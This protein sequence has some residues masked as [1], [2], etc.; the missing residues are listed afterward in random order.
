MMR[1]PAVWALLFA[2][3]ASA[4][5]CNVSSAA[6]ESVRDLIQKAR[7]QAREGNHRGAAEILERARMVAPN[8]E[9]VLGD[10]A[11]NNLAAGNPGGAMDA[12]DPLTR[13]HPTVADYFY[14]LGVAQLRIKAHDHAVDTLRHS[15]ELDPNRALTWIALGITLNSQK[16]F[17]EAKEALVHALEIEP[18]D[19]EALVAIAEAEEGLG[20]LELV[21]V[22]ANRALALAGSHPGAYYALGKARMSQG[23]FAEARDFFLQTVELSP[24]STKA[25]YQL[26][27][28]YARLNDLENSKKHRELHQQASDRESAHIVEMR[29]RAGMGMAGMGPE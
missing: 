4:T 25:H 18:E 9:E 20:E 17:A 10:Y 13:M 8:S 24:Y 26:S 6:T 7:A 27:L 1:R 29:A 19:V 22:H 15:L 28:A 12:L 3:A 14:L 5:L 23:E 2:I 21:D 11:K 16:R